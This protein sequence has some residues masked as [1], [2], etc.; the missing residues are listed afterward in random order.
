M[1]ALSPESFLAIS[2]ECFGNLRDQ[3]RHWR[4]AEPAQGPPNRE[5]EQRR[6]AQRPARGPAASAP[7]KRPGRPKRN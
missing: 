4:E 1:W 6:C 7:D 2:L 5:S 3:I